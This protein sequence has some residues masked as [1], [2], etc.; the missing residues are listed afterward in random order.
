MDYEHKYDT[1]NRTLSSTFSS[2]TE[3]RLIIDAL[4]WLARR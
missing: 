4:R 1:T 2:A 3:N